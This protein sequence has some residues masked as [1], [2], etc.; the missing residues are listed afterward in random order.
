MDEA[1]RT[2]GGHG[3]LQSQCH[4]PGWLVASSVIQANR[5]QLYPNAVTSRSSS[6]RPTVISRWFRTRQICGREVGEQ[7]VSTHAPHPTR[8]PTS[9]PL[10]GRRQPSRLRT[11]GDSMKKSAVCCR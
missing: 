2:P 8:V 4:P 6:R 3:L 5:T 9:Q 1:R 10:H 7:H 11:A